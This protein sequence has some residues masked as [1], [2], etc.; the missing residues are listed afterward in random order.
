MLVGFVTAILNLGAFGAILVGTIW[1]FAL[2]FGRFWLFFLVNILTDAIFAFGLHKII[3]VPAGIVGEVKHG[4]TEVFIA[5]VIMALMLYLY[6]MWI[7][8]VLMKFKTQQQSKAYI[9]NT[10]SFLRR[11]EKAK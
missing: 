3:M 1:I 5:F 11:K 4:S 7:E 6:Q 9:L 10:G 8:G 2:T